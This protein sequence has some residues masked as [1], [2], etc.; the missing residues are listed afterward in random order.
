MSDYLGTMI[1]DTINPWITGFRII[2]EDP[3]NPGTYKPSHETHYGDGDIIYVEALF[4]EKVKITGGNIYFIAKGSTDHKLLFTCTL[5]NSSQLVESI[6]CSY[7]VNEEEFEN[8]E[9]SLIHMA[10]DGDKMVFPSDELNLNGM[11]ITYDKRE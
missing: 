7:Q 1:T 11:M 5:P 2:E 8:E 3:Y 10:F 6:I 9:N 4:S